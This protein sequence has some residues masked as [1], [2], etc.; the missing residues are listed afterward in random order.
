MLLQPQTPRKLR[1]PSRL[2]TQDLTDATFRIYL[3]H[4][5]DHA[6]IPPP[7]A[8][9]EDG[10]S[11]CTPSSQPDP[12]ATP[13]PTQ[14][15]RLKA[16]AASSQAASALTEPSLQGFTLSY[17]RRV[18]ELALLAARVV[19]AHAKRKAREERKKLKES[20]NL[21]SQSRSSSAATAKDL[22]PEKAAPKI[23]R[24][25]Q[26]A[27]KQLYMDGSIVL[28]DG[29]VRRIPSD[30]GGG[31]GV[32]DLSALWKANTSTMGSSYPASSHADSTIFSSTTNTSIINTTLSL[33][34]S[35]GYISDPPSTTEESYISLTP[36]FLS[37]HILQA[38]HDLT[39]RNLSIGKPYAGVSSEGVVGEMRRDDRWRYLGVWSVEEVLGGLE[40]EGRVWRMGNGRWD[41]TICD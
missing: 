30:T 32:Q 19:Q 31:G 41:V 34:P 13:R 10:D 15:S 39:D 23:K 3:K 6:P 14:K 7:P 16:K 29:P 27:I 21:T 17:L 8:T 25:F 40:A 22:P 37:P 20:G 18:P 1:H 9:D 24:L 26:W 4:Y 28:W 2:H 5:M 12:W 35:Q 38:L 33:S 11:E 36:S